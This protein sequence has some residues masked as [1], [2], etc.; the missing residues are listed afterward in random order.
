MKLQ[1]SPQHHF[2]KHVK[3][4][5]DEFV[6]EIY[7]CISCFKI[8]SSGCDIL[9]QGDKPHNLFLI[10]QGCISENLITIDGRRF[11]LGEVS[12]HNHLF[13]EIEFFTQRPYQWSVV[14]EADIKVGIIP[15]E[16]L[17]K[18]IK[19]KPKFNF[20]FM[21]HLATDYQDSL[22]ICTYRIMHSLSFNI[23][24]DLLLQHE[25][26][27]PVNA[28]K[29]VAHEAERFGTSSRVYR[30]AIKDLMDKNIIIKDK[31]SIKIKDISLLKAYLKASK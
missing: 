5:Q 8:I 16:N 14:A 12:C 26:S 6:K 25:G 19:N 13:G 2:F 23:A 15:A 27:S 30:R 20:L 1:L 10:S 22:D 17:L 7:N 28:L 29:N 3:D 4:I 18:L 11:Q 24:H 9:S 31:S 21:L